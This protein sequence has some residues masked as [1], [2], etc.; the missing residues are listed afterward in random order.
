MAAILMQQ[1]CLSSSACCKVRSCS[2]PEQTPGGR[3]WKH[4]SLLEQGCMV[5]DDGIPPLRLRHHIGHLLVDGAQAL[6]HVAGE[7]ARLRATFPA[8]A[9]GFCSPTAGTPACAVSAG[10]DQ[11]Y[12]VLG[13]CIP[14]QSCLLRRTLPAATSWFRG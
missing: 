8:P 2:L 9:A 1:L 3:D 6:Q 10:S 5:A 11:H 12:D 7:A 4:L 13:I 14:M